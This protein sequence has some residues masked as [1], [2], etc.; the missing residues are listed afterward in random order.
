MGPP[1][2]SRLPLK[3]AA[4][5]RPNP[6]I[7]EK[8][9]HEKADSKKPAMSR[10]T[11]WSRPLCR[12]PRSCPQ[13]LHHTTATRRG[14]ATVKPAT[15]KS[16]GTHGHN[17]SYEAAITHLMRTI[18]TLIVTSPTASGHYDPWVAGPLS[19]GDP[20]GG[21]ASRSQPRVRPAPNSRPALSL[22]GGASLR[23]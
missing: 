17:A 9:D 16:R 20:K 10:L 19:Q 8:Q 14:V 18:A 21:Q 3:P 12:R 11:P 22:E 5:R 1:S 4:Q 2:P 6:E 23:R 15:P 7:L 13:S